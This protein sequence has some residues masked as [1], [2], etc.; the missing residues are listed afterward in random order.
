M[1]YN[2][3]EK[4]IMEME[5]DLMRFADDCEKAGMEWASADSICSQLEDLKKVVLAHQMPKEGSIAAREVEAL[6]SEAYLTH[7]N[8]LT[9]ARRKVN[10]FKVKYVS[11]Q[12]RLDAIRTILSNKRELFK[13]GVEAA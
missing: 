1:T 11:A 7:L 4:S 10:E 12:A 9:N 8:G 5:S 2:P 13:R 3:Q 6:K